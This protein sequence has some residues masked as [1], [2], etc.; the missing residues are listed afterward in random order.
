MVIET[1]SGR[2]VDL[3]Q[4]KHDDLDIYDIAHS[5][6][7]QCRFSGHCRVYYSVAEHS[8]HVARLLSQFSPEVQ[9]A[10]LL[11]DASEAYLTDMP[12]PVKALMPEYREFEDNLM[13]KIAERF[14]FEYPLHPAIKHAD[15]VML[16]TE[17][18]YL[19]PSKGK[20]GV[21]GE[22]PRVEHNYRPIGMDPKI[23]AT[24]FLDKY[25]ELKQEIRDG[26][27]VR[28]A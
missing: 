17:A 5:L 26:R 6:S 10:G 7:L 15:R 23:A 25:H 19:M 13:A 18:H 4:P 11:H 3:T 8:W 22:M 2:F 28:D 27:S 1:N 14:G 20:G 9:L 12:S 21:W 24:N 16:A